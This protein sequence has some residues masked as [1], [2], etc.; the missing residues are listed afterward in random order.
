ML[1]TYCGGGH[2]KMT[3]CPGHMTL[4]DKG[5]MME[6]GK[7]ETSGATG[8]TVKILLVY[9]SWRYFQ[10]V[11][12]PHSVSKTTVDFSGFSSMFLVFNRAN[13]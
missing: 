6:F 12:I 10:I 9:S 4:P 1:E 11:L 5:K 13:K 8:T 7:T 2:V 3:L